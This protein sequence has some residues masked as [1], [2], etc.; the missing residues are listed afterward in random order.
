MRRL[1]L[2]SALAWE[3]VALFCVLALAVVWRCL[4]RGAPWSWSALCATMG[5]VQAFA[6][7]S[8]AQLGSRDLAANLVSTIV[9]VIGLAL[10]RRSEGQKVVSP[11]EWSDPPGL[12][13]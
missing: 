1:V 8:D 12:P 13:N 3:C 10:T 11:G 7:M 9:L 6:F 5:G 4:V 2:V